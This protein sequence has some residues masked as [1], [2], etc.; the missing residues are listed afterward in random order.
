MD[1]TEEHIAAAQ[2]R[3]V[4]DEKLGRPTPEQVRRLA[5]TSFTL[6]ATSKFASS[7]V[8]AAGGGGVSGLVTALRGIAELAGEGGAV[9]R[10]RLAEFTSPDEQVADAV[11]YDLR[12]TGLV[13]GDAVTGFSLTPAGWRVQADLRGVENDLDVTLPT[14][15]DEAALD[16]LATE[17]SGRLEALE[18]WTILRQGEHGLR[19][20]DLSAPGVEAVLGVLTS[21]ASRNREG[22][23]RVRRGDRT[24]E[25]RAGQESDVAALISELVR[26]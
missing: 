2:L 20:V 18:T 6:S 17:L 24:A 8:S 14:W 26:P 23:V 25:L 10:D 1:I 5:S 4:L 15:T 3:V 9:T 11:I 16:G 7:I 21:W 12:R 13:H 22:T 19:I